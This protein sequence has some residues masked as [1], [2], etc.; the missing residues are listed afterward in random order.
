MDRVKAA[1]FTDVFQ[2]SIINLQSSIHA[3][4]SECRFFRPHSS[5]ATELMIDDR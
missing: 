2:S 4:W 1:R 5:T 3:L